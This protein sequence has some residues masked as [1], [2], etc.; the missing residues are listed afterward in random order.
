MIVA[1]IAIC[2]FEAEKYR[3]AFVSI[4]FLSSRYLGSLL[5]FYLTKTPFTGTAV[6]VFLSFM[7]APMREVQFPRVLAWCTFFL[8][9]VT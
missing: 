1:P 2:K 9:T 5:W 7:N 6:P 4:F 8:V 3:R